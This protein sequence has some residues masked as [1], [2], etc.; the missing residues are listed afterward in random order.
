MADDA[1]KVDLSMLTAGLEEVARA[2]AS[3]NDAPEEA[4]RR[5]REVVGR[6]EA[7]TPGGAPLHSRLDNVRRWLG[8]LENPTDHDRFGGTE[9]LRDHLA[10]QIRLAVAA[11]EDYMRATG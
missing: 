4:A 7:A 5:L 11:L 2:I 9:H 3:P 8:A 6:V 1:L 10:L